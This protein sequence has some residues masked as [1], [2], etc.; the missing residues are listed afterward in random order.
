V[1]AACL[2]YFT[3]LSLENIYSI[4]FQVLLDWN[5][6]VFLHTNFDRKRTW[7]IIYYKQWPFLWFFFSFCFFSVWMVRIEFSFF[8]FLP[9]NWSFQSSLFFPPSY[10]FI[11]FFFF[12]GTFSNRDSFSSVSFFFFFLI[13][14]FN[15]MW[16][17]LGFHVMWISHHLFPHSSF[18]SQIWRSTTSSPVQG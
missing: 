17:I 1:D 7:L 8:L 13:V 2:E 5:K 12:T 9:Q 18:S 16:A 6:R 10:L 11:Y 3:I 4:I 15:M 14:W